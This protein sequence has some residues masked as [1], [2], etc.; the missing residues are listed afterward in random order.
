[1]GFLRPLCGLIA[2][3]QLPERVIPVSRRVA[4]QDERRLWEMGL[5]GKRVYLRRISPAHAVGYPWQYPVRLVDGMDDDRC[6]STVHVAPPAGLMP[7]PWRDPCQR[8]VMTIN[9]IKINK[10]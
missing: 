10:L 3:Q 8:H 6:G 9:I 1:M 4:A 5:G 7:Q 2:I